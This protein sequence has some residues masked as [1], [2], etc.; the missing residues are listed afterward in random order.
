MATGQ[1]LAGVV[2]PT[3]VTAAMST[4]LAVAINYAT[5]GGHSAWVWVAVVGLTVGVFAVSLWMQGGQSAAAGEPVGVELRGVKAEG[6]LRVKKI[7]GG[8]VSAHKVRSGGD[9]AFEDIDARRNDAPQ[10]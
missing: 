1:T 4:G 8:G 7:R 9:M 3:A 2:V 5:G 10:P 6:A